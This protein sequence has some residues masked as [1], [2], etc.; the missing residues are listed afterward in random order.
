MPGAAATRCGRW[1]PLFDEVQ[2]WFAVVAADDEFACGTRSLDQAA[3]SLMP[4]VLPGDLTP[5][6]QRAITCPVGQCPLPRLP[7]KIPAGITLTTGS[8]AVPPRPRRTRVQMLRGLVVAFRAGDL[9]PGLSVF[10]LAVGCGA[11]AYLAHQ[12]LIGRD[13][14]ERRPRSDHPSRSRRLGDRDVGGQARHAAAA[15]S[16][17]GKIPPRPPERESASSVVEAATIIPSTD[18]GVSAATQPGCP[19]NSTSRC[20]CR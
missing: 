20:M 15:S 5:A 18:N 17:H 8:L 11:S 16:A 6:R 3:P 1:K 4:A 9:R 12:Q 10:L 7:L 2:A 13:E 14:R 19:C